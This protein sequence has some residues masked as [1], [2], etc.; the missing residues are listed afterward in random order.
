MHR[1]IG[2]IN[3]VTQPAFTQV[4]NGTPEQCV[5]SVKS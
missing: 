1:R 5:K 3:L 2:R 4:L